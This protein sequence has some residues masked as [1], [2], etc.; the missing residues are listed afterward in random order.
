MDNLQLIPDSVPSSYRLDLT[1]CVIKIRGQYGEGGSFGDVYKCKLKSGS[2]TM[3][4]AVKAFRFRFT[5]EGVDRHAKNLRGELCL[6]KRLSHKNIVPFLGVAH[7]FG[8]RNSTSLVTLWMPNGTL[9]NFLANYN[10]CLTTAH[11]LH[12][13]TDIANGLHYIHSFSSRPIIH[14]DLNLNNVLLDADYSARLTD[15][16]YTSSVG[17]TSEALSY[18]RR[19]S[20]RP[21]S[22]RWF[23]PEQVLCDS[24]E[25]FR[26]TIKSD[27]YSFGNTALQAR[28]HETTFCRLLI[29]P[30]VLSG[31]PPWSEI[32]ED[33]SVIVCLAQGRKPGRPESRPIDDQH[34]EF[35]NTCWSPIQEHR[36]TA[37]CILSTVEQFLDQL[38]PAQP[39]RDLIAS[40][41]RQSHPRCTRSVSRLDSWEH[42][43]MRDAVGLLSG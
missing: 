21:G 13:L 12:L 9:Q 31:K 2:G 7:G 27:V 3:E 39:I 41:S 17:A 38:P 29:H 5:V 11:R 15:F 18:L 19:S 33:T 16:G 26:K 30:Q 8:M 42:K 23:A 35:I 4:V 20:V 10:N 37:K 40:L 34:W 1:N 32:H 14:G 6:W 24:K 36:P 22:L 28:L 25:R 43:G